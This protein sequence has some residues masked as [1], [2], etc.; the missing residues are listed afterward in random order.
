MQAVIN[1]STPRGLDLPAAVLRAQ[2][3]EED[4]IRAWMQRQQ[5]R[6][7]AAA[8]PLRA[9]ARGMRARRTLHSAGAARSRP[10]GAP[11]A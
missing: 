4:R 7:L 11:C 10:T 1:R 5:E 3:L 8:V 2:G 9:L 6:A